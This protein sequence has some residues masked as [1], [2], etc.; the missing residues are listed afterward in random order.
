MYNI[1]M[2]KIILLTFLLFNCCLLFA[3]TT[4]VVT[5][6]VDG[7]TMS[8]SNDFFINASHSKNSS[9][10]FQL[11]DTA[12]ISQTFKSDALITVF[13]PDNQAFLKLDKAVLDTLLKPAHKQDLVKLLLSHVLTGKVTSKDIA[14]QINL[15]NGQAVLTTMANT[16][17]IATIDANR[18]I[19]LT[20]ENGNKSVISKFDILQKNGILDIVTSVLISKNTQP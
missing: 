1:F 2:K 20:N 11:V 5:R 7:T 14:K 16:K 12:G 6:T 17:L 3:Q 10:F 19:V 8:S 9:I 13:A 18:N 15:N 4:A